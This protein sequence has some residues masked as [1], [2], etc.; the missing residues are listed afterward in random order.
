MARRR[1]SSSAGDA[2]ALAAVI[3]T[4]LDPG[5]ARVALARAA[6]TRVEEQFT[7]GRTDEAVSHMLDRVKI[8][9]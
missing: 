3:D 7:V 1:K 5:V 8:R 2:G 6:R 4:A 9:R